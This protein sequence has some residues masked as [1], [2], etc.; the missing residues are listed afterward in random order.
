MACWITVGYIGVQQPGTA[1][2]VARTSAAWSQDH[3][4]QQQQPDD[5]R[6]PAARINAHRAYYDHQHAF[7]GTSLTDSACVSAL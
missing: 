1:L 7:W 3:M 6:A 4:E 2:C 5:L